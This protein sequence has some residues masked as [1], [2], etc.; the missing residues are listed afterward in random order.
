[1]NVNLGTKVMVYNVIISMNASRIH[2]IV[3]LME[4][5]VI[6]MV[7]TNVNVIMDMMVLVMV[8]LVAQILTN[9]MQPTSL[10]LQ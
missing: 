9:A 7:V 5:V 3:T 2:T 4:S 1:M 8:L 10:P 6:L